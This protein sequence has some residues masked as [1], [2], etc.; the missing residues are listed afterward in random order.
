MSLLKE[1][2]ACGAHVTPQGSV[3]LAWKTVVDHLSNGAQTGTEF[4]CKDVRAIRDWFSLFVP[5]F[6]FDYLANMPATGSEDD[7]NEHDRLVTYVVNAMYDC[8]EGNGS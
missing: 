4:N 7:Y 3:L 1:V 2:L 6:K 8:A 5:N